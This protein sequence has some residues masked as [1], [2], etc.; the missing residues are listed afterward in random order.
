MWLWIHHMFFVIHYCIYC[1]ILSLF[2]NNYFLMFARSV[3]D[4]VHLV[5]CLN[6]CIKNSSLLEDYVKFTFI[7][8]YIR[9]QSCLF[10]LLT[11]VFMY[12]EEPNELCSIYIYFYTKKEQFLDVSILYL[13]MWYSIIPKFI[14]IYATNDKKAIY[15]IC[16]ENIRFF[17]SDLFSYSVGIIIKNE[18]CS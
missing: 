3:C 10:S 2:K 11:I 1:Y 15:Y 9:S 4:L 18:I 6:Q 16:G 14:L 12:W 7:F 5:H 8:Y 13:E 17:V